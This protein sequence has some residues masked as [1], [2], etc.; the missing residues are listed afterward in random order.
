VHCALPVS[1][2]RGRGSKRLPMAGE[3]TRRAGRPFT[4]ARIET[5]RRPPYAAP[6][7]SRPFT[8]ARIETAGWNPRRETLESPL[9]GGADRNQPP[10]ERQPH[11]HGRPF[12]GARIETRTSGPSVPPCAVAPSRG[13]GSKLAL[14]RQILQRPESP[15]HGGADRNASG[16][17]YEAIRQV[18]PSRGRGSK[19]CARQGVIGMTDVAPS[20]GRGSKL[21]RATPSRSTRGRPFTGARIETATSRRSRTARRVAPSRGRG[22]KRSIRRA[23]LRHERVAPS[24]GRGSKLLGDLTKTT[25]RNVAPSRGRG[26]KQAGE[27]PIDVVLLSPLHGGA[28]RNSSLIEYI[29]AY[30]GRP[31]TGARIETSIGEASIHDRARRPFTGARIETL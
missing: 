3:L 12:T 8:G 9:H 10:P 31:F 16:P 18:A 1:P 28:D 6:P 23:G 25:F 22:S 2:S 27:V 14:R 7:W 5:T 4:G 19:Q 13:R 24:R 21:R 17:E 30:C 11:R 20:R 26:S 29:T 15:L